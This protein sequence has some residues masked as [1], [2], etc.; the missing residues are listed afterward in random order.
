MKTAILFASALVSGMSFSLIA[1]QPAAGADQ[2]AGAPTTKVD[3]SAAASAQTTRTGAAAHLSEAAYSYMRPV[4]CELAGKL[5]SKSARTGDA[6]VA[7]TTERF[8]AADG[9][10][11][12]KGA[13]LVGHVTDV[14]A[15]TSSQ[16]DSHLSI[17][18]DRVEWSSGNSLPVR[19]VIQAVTKPVNTFASTPADNTD[20]IASP[21]GAGTHGMG[22][23]RAGGGSLGAAGNVGSTTGNLGTSVGTSASTG[24]G[25]LRT[26]GQAAGD[27]TGNVGP[28]LASNVGPVA[29][30]GVSA[31]T[32]ASMGIHPSGVPGVM[33]TGDATG[34]TAGTLSAS[35]R[36]VHLDSGTQLTIAVSAAVS[37]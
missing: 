20:P 28:S 13:K 10:V 23:V 4:N 16:P 3:Q 36:N 22:G 1:Q 2:G 14:Q 24:G 29:S 9:T 32:S 18:F 26:A 21:V 19:S 12:P 15:H 25:G 11:V 30:T 27:A 6:V 31:A 34:A 7:R 37:Q 5:D 33:L 17:A 35:N 8:L